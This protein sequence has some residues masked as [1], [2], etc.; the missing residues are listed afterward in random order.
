MKEDILYTGSGL[1]LPSNIGLAVVAP[2]VVAIGKSLKKYNLPEKFYY[3]TTKHGDPSITAD[4]AH[5][6]VFKNRQEVDVAV[7]TLNI[8]T[9]ITYVLWIFLTEFN[10]QS[11]EFDGILDTLNDM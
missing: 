4:K 7:R 9:G 6:T 5:A 10:E 1:M 8:V 3:L 11:I 2:D